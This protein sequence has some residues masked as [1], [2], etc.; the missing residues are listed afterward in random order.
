[1]LIA[2]VQMASGPDRTKNLEV[3]TRLVRR[4]AERGAILV[5]LPENVAW[6]GSEKDRPAAAER[7]D[8]PSL[9]RLAELARQL[10]I[11]LLAGLHHGGRRSRR[12]AST[13]PASCSG[14]TGEHL[15]VYRKIHLFD[16]EV[17]DGATYRESDAVAPGEA[18]VTAETPLGTVGLSICYD[19]RFP[20]LYR[21]LSR[22]ARP[23]SP[24][25][26]RSP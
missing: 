6:M 26:R 11:H 16:A 5:G 19:L 17:G 15:A 22:P 12:A 18:P 8:G 1:M 10:R 9:T 13:T 23:C 20:E 2:A 4:A 25:R 24:S 21:A 3:A 14:P 7:L